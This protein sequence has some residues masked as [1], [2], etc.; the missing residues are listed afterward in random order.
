MYEQLFAQ[1]DNLA[2]AYVCSGNIENNKKTILRFLEEEMDYS[3]HANPNLY[4]HQY[5][6]MGISDARDITDQQQKTAMGTGNRKIFIICFSSITVEAQN[7]LLKTIEEPTPDTLIFLLTDA[8]ENLLSTILSRAQLLSGETID[9]YKDLVQE[10]IGENFIGREKIYK[11]F[12][13]DTKKNIP[14]NKSGATQFI[15]EI[16][17]HISQQYS[18][19]NKTEIYRDIEQMQNYIMNRSSSLKYIFEF[20]SLRVPHK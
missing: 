13:S 16:L 1:K 12:L 11:Q 8:V 19:N 15:S 2:H 9:E 10:F 18:W 3:V 14:A 20:I 4:I 5:Q 17:T 7:A 6:S